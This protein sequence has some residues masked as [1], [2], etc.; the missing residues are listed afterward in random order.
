MSGRFA[1]ENL[2]R[3]SALISL[4]LSLV[5]W[6]FVDGLGQSAGDGQEHHTVDPVI[7]QIW[8]MADG[9]IS[10][11]EVSRAWIWGPERLE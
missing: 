4:S 6:M 1:V 7:G 3:I 2:L 8:E 5:T 11:N 9:P 10:R